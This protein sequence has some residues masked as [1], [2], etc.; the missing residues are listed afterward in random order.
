MR[1]TNVGWRPQQRL[2]QTRA[3]FLKRIGRLKAFVAG[4]INV[5]GVSNDGFPPKYIENTF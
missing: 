4:I 1:L 2:G 3:H 5:T